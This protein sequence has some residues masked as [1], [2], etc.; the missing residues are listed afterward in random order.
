MKQRFVDRPHGRTVQKHDGT[1]HFRSD[2]W[3]LDASWST[4]KVRVGR[5][6]GLSPLG[7]L[8]IHGLGNNGS[9]VYMGMME[10]E[11]SNSLGIIGTHW[12]IGVNR[13]FVLR[14]ARRTENQVS[15][16][17]CRTY[18]YRV[19][20]TGRTAQRCGQRFCLAHLHI[21]R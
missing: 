4:A 5:N 9:L 17:T 14:R 16:F 11:E 8:C 3:S 19:H 13:I 1:W 12:V 18:T 21:R 20:S 2:S 7:G 6:D 15:H 10:A